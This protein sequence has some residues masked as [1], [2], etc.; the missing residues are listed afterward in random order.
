MTSVTLI[1][2]LP[3]AHGQPAVKGR[4]RTF[5][6]DFQVREELDFPLDGIGEHVW[7]WVRKRGANTDWVAK[8]LAA[9]AQVPP[10]AV[11]YAGLKDRH[12]VTE[13]W[14][15]VHLPGKAEPDWNADPQ[16]DFTVLRAV[17]HSRKLRRG[18]L[19]GNTFRIVIRDLD[20]D[21]AELANQWQRIIAVGVPNYFGEQRFG[22]E[23][24]NLERAE[25]MFS[26]QAKVRD[27]HQRSLYL[28]AA[29][30]ALF[31]AVLAKRVIAEIW[32]QAL[33]GEVLMLAG[34]HSIFVA[35][36]VDETLRQRIAEFDLHPTGPL[37]GAGELLSSGAIREL[38]EEVTAMLPLF[39]D[40]LAAAGLK[41]ERRALRLILKDAVLELPQPDIA[42]F[43]FRL[44]AGAYAT[45]VMRELIEV[46]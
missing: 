27:R 37:W 26:G 19:S 22:R 21:P 28:S 8:Q 45:T 24:G 30:S 34:S 4:M 23:A 15:S 11:S 6:E 42:I 33:P 2:S 40:G 18:T 1:D 38:E 36:E 14:F 31:N 10:G 3:F 20:G 41:Q 13:Q 43:A 17:R 7:L 16:P 25:A 12:A 29:R 44:P 39:R 35:S 5:P 32:N 9:R 46:V